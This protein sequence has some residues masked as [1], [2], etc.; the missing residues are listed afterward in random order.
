LFKLLIF[1]EQRDRKKNAEKDKEKDPLSV[2]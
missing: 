2:I 1:I